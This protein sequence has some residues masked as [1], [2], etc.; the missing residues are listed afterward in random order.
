MKE[1]VYRRA[2][3]DGLRRRRKEIAVLWLYEEYTA[4]EIAEYSI[5]C[6]RTVERDIRYIESHLNE[7]MWLD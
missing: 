5:Y 1:R 7:F 2:T 4:E 3:P 6:E